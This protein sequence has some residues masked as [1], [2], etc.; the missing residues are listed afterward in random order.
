MWGVK[1]E[2]VHWPPWP[3]LVSP[4]VP[5]AGL[6]GWEDLKARLCLTHP[7]ALKLDRQAS[8]YGVCLL[9]PSGT[10]PCP[11]AAALLGQ[12]VGGCSWGSPPSGCSAIFCGSLVSDTQPCC[13][14]AW[15]GSRRPYAVAGVRQALGARVEQGGD[16][17][18]V[19]GGDPEISKTL[20][21]HRYGGMGS[22]LSP[23]GGLLTDSLLFVSCCWTL[24]RS[25][26]G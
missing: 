7:M 6:W 2:G 21:G 16:L 12:P 25:F 18:E 13:G 9:G 4:S 8:A 24:A 26:M 1:E 22:S 19:V 17:A 20:D 15:I 14:R 3:S 5:G 11:D 10:F 23:Q